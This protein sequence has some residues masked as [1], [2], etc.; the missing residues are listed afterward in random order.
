MAELMIREMPNKETLEAFLRGYF[1]PPEVV[2]N[3]ER[4][5][6]EWLVELESRNGR[7]APSIGR[8]NHG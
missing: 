8:N 3:C 7:E 1:Q 2:F 5:V 6:F 4:G